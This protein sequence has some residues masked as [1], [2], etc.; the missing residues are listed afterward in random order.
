MTTKK[1]MKYSYLFQHF[2]ASENFVILKN[3]GMII[4]LSII[5]NALEYI[6]RRYCH[7]FSL[8]GYLTSIFFASSDTC[9]SIR[10]ITIS[11]NYMMRHTIPMLAYNIYCFFHNKVLK[12]K[13]EK[14]KES[15]FMI[16]HNEIYQDNCT[17][18]R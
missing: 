8:I 10:N 2:I 11:C 17:Y 6:Y 5:S 15:V 1:T 13:G 3:F 14:E 12:N 18:T 9:Q 7:S 16:T 4:I